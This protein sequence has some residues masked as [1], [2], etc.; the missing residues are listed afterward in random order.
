M[1][2]ATGLGSGLDI[3][4]LVT[5]LVAAER[6]GSDLQLDRKAAKYNSKFSA[7]GS[8]KSALSSFQSSFGS[9]NSLS[10]YDLNKAS[11]SAPSELSISADSTAIPSSYSIDVTQLATSHTLA[12]TAFSDSDSTALGEGTLTLRFGTTDYTSGTDT[13]NSFSLNPESSTV[14]IDIDSS[15]NTLEGIMTAINDADAGVSAAIVN[16]GAGFRLLISSDSTGLENSIEISVDDDDGNDTDT[17]GLSNFVFN[18]AATNME[19][20]ADAKDALLSVNGLAVTSSSNSVSTVIPGAQ[21]QLHQ[22]TTSSVALVIEEDRGAITGGINSFIAG[23]NQFIATVNALSAYDV[24]QDLPSALVGDFTLRSISGQI[25]SVLRSAVSGIT[26]SIDNLA[27]LGISTS[28][29]GTLT[30][31]QT[32]LNAVLDEDPSQLSK[33]FAAIGIA[34]DANISYSGADS[35]TEIGD[36]AIEISTLASSGVYSSASVLPDFGGGGSLVIDADNDNLSVEIDG[37]DSGVLTLTAATYTDGASL[38]NEI[39]A[40]INGADSIRDAGRTVTVEYLSGSDSFSITS[41]TLGGDSTVNVLTVDTNTAAELGFSVASGTDGSDVAGT[42]DGIV[43]SGVGNILTAATGSGAEGLSLKIEGTTTGSRGSVNFTR[44]I[45]N[46][47]DSLLENL[48]DADGALEDRIDSFKDRID[49]V[50]ARRAELEL[51]WEAVEARYSRQ[52]NAL[53]ALLAGLQSTSEYMEQQF[54]NLV[55]PNTGR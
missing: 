40:Q 10:N 37:I 19:Q 35:V 45:A 8:V 24:E 6:A 21:L 4:G 29:T 34:S 47:L 53:D 26:G 28:Q 3:S 46:Q 52:F 14:T 32:R 42:I 50:A 25:D 48:L 11:S 27:E 36:Y 1:I 51:R 16:D 23:Y 31:D 9:L 7:L 5:Q 13:Y 30:L 22:L 33:V 38:A 41:N 17:S 18:S 54:K 44:G 20:T 55:E 43:A 15:N 12:S 49:E 2:T 39:Q